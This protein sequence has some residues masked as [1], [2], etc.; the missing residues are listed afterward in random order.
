MT[1]FDEEEEE[2][3]KEEKEEDGGW[4]MEDAQ[5]ERGEEAGATRVTIQL[6]LMYKCERRGRL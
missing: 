6:Q 5:M 1:L 2:E 3:E 4:R